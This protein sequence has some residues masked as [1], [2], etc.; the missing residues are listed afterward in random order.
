MPE[1]ASRV[2]HMPHRPKLVV[3][4]ALCFAFAGVAIAV[5][6]N[7][8]PSE[9]AIVLAVWTVLAVVPLVRT[10]RARIEIS[11]ASVI[12]AQVFMTRNFTRADVDRFELASSI[13]PTGTGAVIRQ[14]LVVAVLTD[15]RRIVLA[16]DRF[17]LAG[18]PGMQY[19]NLIRELNLFLAS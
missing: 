9:V 2:F 13:R 8:T 17:R 18:R 12:A 16:Q 3:A 11:P 7:S 6:M 14:A 5:F 1:S 10:A 19:S 4:Y 15:G